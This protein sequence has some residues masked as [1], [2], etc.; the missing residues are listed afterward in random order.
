LA[1]IAVLL[2]VFFAV[3]LFSK[4]VSHAPIVKI[5]FSQYQAVPNFSDYPHVVT[6]EKRLDAFRTLVSRYSI[7]V[8]NYDKALN[9]DCTGGLTTNITLRFGDATTQKLQIYDCGK[10]TA[11]GT[12]V[13]DA[14]ALFS[15][16]RAAD[17]GS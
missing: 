9:D 5:E 11:G 16:W 14:T 12:F 10:P 15:K 2:A 13:T 4:P 17:T 7:D 8:R 6:D 1:I 3:Q